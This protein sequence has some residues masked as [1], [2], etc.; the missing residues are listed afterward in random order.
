MVKN[1]LSVF[2]C[3]CVSIFLL[4]CEK[5]ETGLNEK[6][7]G[8]S[9]VSLEVRV[10]S[11][12]DALVSNKL[13]QVYLFH[14]PA[15]RKLYSFGQFQGGI[16]SS[17]EWLSAS[18]RSAAINGNRADVFVDVQHRLLLPGAQGER[19]NS[20]VGSINSSVHE[21]W[22][23]EDGEWWYIGKPGDS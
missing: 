3:L 21:V 8:I 4:S 17:V 9:K 11:R 10:S 13:D 12:W 19:F 7:V 22:L 16:G 6:Q 23:W 1:K 2:L 18:L 5:K 20:S 15:R 14:S